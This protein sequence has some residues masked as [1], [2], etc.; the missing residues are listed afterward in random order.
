DMFAY[1]TTPR[2]ARHPRPVGACSHAAERQ[3]CFLCYGIF[4]S[5]EEVKEHIVSVHFFPPL[6]SI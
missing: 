1:H 6:E 3:Q 5:V 2:A 4:G